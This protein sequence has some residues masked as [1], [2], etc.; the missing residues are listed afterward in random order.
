MGLIR[1][2]LAGRMHLDV[3]SD[4]GQLTRCVVAIVG[5]SIVSH[6]VQIIV[7]LGMPLAYGGNAPQP[8]LSG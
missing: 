8:L 7:S 1:G 6:R 2:L 4:A 3:I 5:T